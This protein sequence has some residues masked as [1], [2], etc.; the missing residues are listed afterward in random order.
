MRAQLASPL[1]LVLLLT[2]CNQPAVEQPVEPGTHAGSEQSSTEPAKALPDAAIVA[3]AAVATSEQT[4]PETKQSLAVANQDTRAELTQRYAEIKTMIG[5]A[6]ASDVK[7]CRKVAFG[8]K[9]CGGP[10]SYLIYSVVGLDEALLLEKVAQYNAL[11]EAE[12]R[13][14]GLISNCAMVT[15]PGVILEGGVCKAGP[16]GDLY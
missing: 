13:R 1:L 11:D 4:M 6:K 2:G 12:T 16:A 10:A 3:A 7:Q 9:A 14:L 8:Y 15:E 5:Q